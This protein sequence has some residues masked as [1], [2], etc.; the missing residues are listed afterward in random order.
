VFT[1]LLILDEEFERNVRCTYFR[2][3]CYGDVRETALGEKT[4]DHAR[5]FADFYGVIDLARRQ[6]DFVLLQGSE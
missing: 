5:C 2:R 6:A 3:H 1:F 4:P